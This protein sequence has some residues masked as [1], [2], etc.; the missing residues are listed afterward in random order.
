MSTIT[1]LLKFAKPYPGRIILTIILGFSGALFNGVSTAMIVPIILNIVGQ[2]IDL[3]NAPPIINSIISPFDIFPE[4]YRMIIMAGAIILVIFL[5]NVASYASNL[6]SS[7]VARTLTSDMRREGVKL[8][9][10]IDIT[11]HT[12]MRLGDLMT[13]VNSE[14]S[15][16]AISLNNIVKLIITVI[17]I[18][19][20]IFILLSISWQLTIVSTVLLAFV[21][22]INQYAIH[23]SKYYGEVLT[24]M[25]QIQTSTL[26]ETWSGIRLVKATANEE[27]TYQK[28][29]ELIHNREAAEFQSQVNSNIIGPTSEVAGLIALIL[30][31]FLGRVLFAEQVASLSAVLLTYLLVLMRLLPFVSQL[32]SLRSS[33]ANNSASVDVVVDFLRRDNKPLMPNGDINYTTLQAGVHFNHISFA[34]PGHDKLVLKDV[35][36]YLPKGTTLALVGSSGAGKSTLADLLPRFYDPISGSIAIDDIDIRQFDIKSLRKAMGI[37]SQDTFLFNDSIKHN[38]AYGKS[39]ASDEEILAA[40]KRA[41]AYEFISKLPQGFDTLIGDRGVMLSGGQRQRLAIARALLQDPEILILDEATSA[42]DTV[43]ERLVQAAIDDL[44]RDRTTLVIAHRL[45]TIQ[46]AHQIAV[47]DQGRVVE[48]GTHEELLQKGG[49]YS[50]LYSMQFGDQLGSNQQ[51]HQILTRLSYEIRTRLN[52]IIGCLGLLNDGMVDDTKER[53]E[54]LNQSYKSALRVITNIEVFQE[55]LQLK[56]DWQSFSDKDDH[57]ENSIYVFKEIHTNLNN[58]LKT[59]VVLADD[60]VDNPQEEQKLINES[61]ELSI[62]LLDKIKPLEQVKI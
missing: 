10:D 36:L 13:N 35:D 30:I 28:I 17:T 24:K 44:S 49:Y 54:L 34:Y 7:A 37:V 11:Y 20:F 3:T 39:E 56:K 16:A 43:S 8:L 4:N 57:H 21:T 41:N 50:R 51:P 6:S 31:V 47:F 1:Q 58:M 5:K 33:F 19:V 46:K 26:I 2:E 55:S 25:S 15:R 62:N 48:T 18:L 40:S 42:L 27:K 14:I 32:N 12:K 52:S 38:I 59:L 9:L 29:N 22:L 61:Y 23:R 53:Y 45:S 60:L